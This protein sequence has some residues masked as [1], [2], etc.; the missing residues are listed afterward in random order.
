MLKDFINR[1]PTFII[2]KETTNLLWSLLNK[3]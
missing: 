1:N 2:I 3:T